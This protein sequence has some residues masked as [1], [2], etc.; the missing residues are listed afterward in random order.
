V[1]D[2]IERGYR[3]SALRYLLIS[4]HYRKSL[5]FSWDILGQADAAL[6]RLADF[7]ARLDTV[8]GGGVHD[9]VGERLG[10]AREEFREHLRRDLNVPA[11]LG[12]VFD[13]V[14]EMNAA[15]DARDIGAAD[16]ALVR[17]T[18]DGFDE[19]LGVLRL[20]RQEDARPPV[21]VE[22]I[23]QLI[24][25]R[26]LA[27]HAREFARADEIRRDL[28]ARGIV[29]EDTATGTRWKRG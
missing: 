4:V 8:A 18:F 12:V 13:L 19:V 17:E 27:R 5:T 29:L 24:E 10:R 21:P 6:T 25:E 22:Q 16:A 23:E 28:E 3:A 7:L 9:A 15:M 26:R 20:R 2:V 14:R 1:R 11:A